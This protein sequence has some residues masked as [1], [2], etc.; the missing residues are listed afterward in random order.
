MAVENVPSKEL[1]DFLRVH[2]IT[3]LATTSESGIA[4]AST[5]YYY[6]EDDLRFYLLTKHDTFKF[7]NLSKNKSV[8]LVVTDEQKL[9]TVQI[10]GTAKEVN[11]ANESAPTVKKFI[12]NLAKNGLQ[13][14]EL[15]VNHLDA[16]YYAFVQI[17]P[18]WIRWSDFKNWKHTVKF[19]QRF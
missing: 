19:E 4:H 5:T 17:T 11:Y 13:W 16:G 2:D 12:E 6:V 15:P 9:Q 14:D 10:E 3:A 7:K 18:T 8:A 1:L